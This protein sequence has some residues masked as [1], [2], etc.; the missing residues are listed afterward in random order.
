LG[1]SLVGDDHHTRQPALHHIPPLH[2]ARSQ[3][4]LQSNPITLLL[5]QFPLH[6]EGILYC[7]AASFHC[8]MYQVLQAGQGVGVMQLE[9]KSPARGG[10]AGPLVIK[11]ADQAGRQTRLRFFFCCC[12]MRSAWPSLL[13]QDLLTLSTS[14]VMIGALV[15]YKSQSH[16]NEQHWAFNGFTNAFKS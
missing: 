3:P 1:Y 6:P 5:Y 13:I 4:A 9:C 14:G 11:V 16:G 12:D 10:V 8:Y 15:P 7:T 2:T